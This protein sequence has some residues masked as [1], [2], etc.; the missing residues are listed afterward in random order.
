MDFLMVTKDYFEY[1]FS[2][3][4]SVSSCCAHKQRIQQGLCMHEG[5]PSH[6][7]MVMIM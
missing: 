6:L 1:L 2:S 5:Y 4:Y 7:F 3:V